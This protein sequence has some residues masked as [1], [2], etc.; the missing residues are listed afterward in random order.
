[1][2]TTQAL[3]GFDTRRVS[4]PAGWIGQT[5]AELQLHDQFD[6]QVVGLLDRSA[7]DDE[8]QVLFSDTYTTPLAAGDVLVIYGRDEKLDVLET[9]VAGL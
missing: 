4:V 2:E 7:G 1:M 9:A 8:P 3:P 5:L 6:V